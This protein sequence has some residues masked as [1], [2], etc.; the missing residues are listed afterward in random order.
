MKA[1]FDPL[2]LRRVELATVQEVFAQGRAVEQHEARRGVLSEKM[3]QFIAPYHDRLYQERLALL[4]DE[5]Q[6][7]IRKPEKERT[8]REQKV[9]DDYYPVLRI[10][11]P[12]IK[13]VM[14]A[15]E[16]KQ[17]EEYLKQINELKPPQPL[18][19]FWTVEEDAR[20]AGETGTWGHSFVRERAGQ[21]RTQGSRIRQG[22]HA[23]AGNPPGVVNSRF[24]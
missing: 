17:Y 24:A 20:R 12:K 8:V 14:P 19:A 11:P 13:E 10:D 22:L 21:R 23:G 2:V 9:A 1:L 6:A 16:V 7:A 5:V 15:E 3:R 4:P 18:P